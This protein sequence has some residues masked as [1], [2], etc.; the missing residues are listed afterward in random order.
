MSMTHLPA[1]LFQYTEIPHQWQL[2]IENGL[3]WIM[4]N[5]KKKMFSCL[6]VQQ[7]SNFSCFLQVALQLPVLV[8]H[9]TNH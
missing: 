6:Y 7:L 2:W 4:G 1:M 3:L 8:E 9:F 5:I